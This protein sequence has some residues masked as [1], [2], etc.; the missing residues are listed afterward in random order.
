[1]TSPPRAPPGPLSGKDRLALALGTW[2][3]CGFVPRAPGTAGTLGA[4]P[5][6][7]LLARGGPWLVL[8]AGVLVTLLGVWAAGRVVVQ[9]RTPDPQI[10]CIDEVAGVLLVLAVAPFT[11]AGIVTAVVLFRIFDMT[12]PWPA[13]ALERLPAGWGVMMDDVAAGAWGAALVAG[14]RAAGWL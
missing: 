12:K 5:L 8:A 13:R 7:L 9:R 3:G 11:V 2:F 14:A 10:V 1:M 4:L 6:Y